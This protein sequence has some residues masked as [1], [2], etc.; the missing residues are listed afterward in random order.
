MINDPRIYYA[1]AAITTRIKHGQDRMQKESIN[2]SK[3]KQH[4]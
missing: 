4:R 1:Q 2:S 3:Q